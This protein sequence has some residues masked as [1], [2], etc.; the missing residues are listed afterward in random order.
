M[1]LYNK[2]E[3]LKLPKGTLFIFGPEKRIG[4][5]EP[6]YRSL[7]VKYESMTNDFVYKALIDI[8]ADSSETLMEIDDRIQKE[9]RLNGISSNI[10]MDLDCTTRD[11]LYEEKATYI[12]FD[13]EEIKAIIT[14]LQSLV[15]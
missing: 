1:K 13:N 12:V 3:F 4:T 15:K 2:E 14:S 7:N 9:T 11:G 5:L 8:D 10:P 6:S